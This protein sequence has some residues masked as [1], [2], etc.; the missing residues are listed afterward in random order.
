M[1]PNVITDNSAAV[2][3]FIRALLIVVAA[4][5]PGLFSPEQQ[6]AIIALAVASI[7]LSGVTVTTTVPKTPSAEA[8]PK[9]AQIPP[10]STP[11]PSPVPPAQ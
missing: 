6:Q 10:A 4:F 8:L 11:A 2:V 1:I 7:A 9:A 5:W 3:G